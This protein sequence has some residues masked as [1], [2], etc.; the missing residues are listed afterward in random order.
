MIEN[1]SLSAS[2]KTAII[3]FLGNAYKDSRVVNLIDSLN[4]LNFKTNTISFDWKTPNFNSQYGQTVI[5]KLDKS[6]SSL[7]FYLNF[8]YLLIRDLLKTKAN[9]YFA[10]DIYTLP[11]TYFFAKKNKAKIFYNSREIY[12]HLGGLRNKNTIQKIISKIESKFIRKVDL[13]LVT[14]EMDADYLR[15][16]YGIDKFFVLRNLPKFKEVISKIDLR[17]QLNISQER[18]ILLYQGVILEGRGIKKTIDLIEKIPNIHFV[19]VGE[20]EFR[21]KFEKYS[22]EKKLEK[23]IHFI[24]AVNHSELLNYT[25]GADIGLALI[26]NISISYYYAL[27]N[28]LFEYIMAGIPIFASNLPQMKKVIDEYNVGKYVDPENENEMIKNLEELIKDQ[29]LLSDF[30]ANCKKA[31]KILNWENEFEKFKEL[32]LN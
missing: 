29:K 31:S 4:K 23:R 18:K 27:P 6:K 30:T 21:N 15:D 2:K 24:G 3:T 9:Y 28:K 26:E 13:V 17:S 16:S 7:S 12:A 8:F 32:H 20:G 25:A 19:I 22:V 5:H 1:I 14:G 11:I 10:E